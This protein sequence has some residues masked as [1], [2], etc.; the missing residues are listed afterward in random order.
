MRTRAGI[1]LLLALTS[2]LTAGCGGSG[3]NSGEGGGTSGGGGTTSAN[4]PV[5]A[6]IAPSAIP[7]GTAGT[8]LDVFGTNFQGGAA[9]EWNGNELVTNQP[10]DSSGQFSSTHL[11]AT[12][13]AGDLASAGTAQI[14]VANTNAAGFPTSSPV[15]FT[16]GAAV[17][18]AGTTWARA[19]AGISAP[20]DVVRDAADGTVYVS[21]SSSDPTSPNTIIPVNPETGAA[22]TPVAAGSN[23]DLLSISSDSSYLWAGLDGA[24]SVQRFLLPNLTKDIS[25]ALPLDSAGR[26]QQAVSL[27][28]ARESPHTVAYRNF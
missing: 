22:G 8:T 7:A 5:I 25:F 16:I 15:A 1:G 18:P 14:T 12:V 28:A 2:G 27:E 13:P 9:V 26:A 3:T 10:V 19:V 24:Y 21:V 20:N 6:S 17:A 11:T 4:A 23:P